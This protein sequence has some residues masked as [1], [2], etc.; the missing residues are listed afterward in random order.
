MHLPLL[1]RAKKA[2]KNVARSSILQ[3]YN[4]NSS[5]NMVTT[6]NSPEYEKELRYLEFENQPSS[7]FKYQ[8]GFENNIDDT[9][10]DEW[11]ELSEGAQD[12]ISG[13]LNCEPEKRYCQL[14]DIY[15]LSLFW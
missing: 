14:L 13:M 15:F 9:E 3:K 10:Y 12:L 6:T 1:H 2:Q 4:I 5:D 7:E 8:K 11:G